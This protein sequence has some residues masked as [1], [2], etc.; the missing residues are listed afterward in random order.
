[1]NTADDQRFMQAALA[2]AGRG[3]G[4]TSPNP[5]VGCII[6]R[7]GLVVGRGWTQASGRPHAEAMALDQAGAAAKEATAYVTLEPCAHTSPRGPACADLLIKAG[8]ARVV[9]AVEDPDPR[10]S[11]SGLA[12]LNAAGITTLVGIGKMQAQEQLQS[13]LICQRYKRPMVTL[14]LATSLDGYSALASGESQWITGAIARDHAHMERSRVDAILIGRG[15]LEADNPALDVRLPG[16]DSRSPVPVVVSAGLTAMPNHSKLAHNPKTILIAS[17]DPM[18]ILA[19]FTAKGM[20]H[21]MVEGGVTLASAFLQADLV[22]RLLLYRA[23]ILLGAGKHLVLDL[24]LTALAEAHNQWR[25]SD[26]RALGA[27]R[28]DIFLRVRES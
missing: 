6:V 15:T 2:L 4:R 12:R 26:T 27:D 25:Q 14:K 9:V 22:D 7:D 13:Y 21:I 10:T 1:M 23:P 28:L 5:S 11:G 18:A 8:I 3:H 24:G 19:A 17:R 16:L 20:V